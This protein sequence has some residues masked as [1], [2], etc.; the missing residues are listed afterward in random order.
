MRIVA[1]ENIPY[2]REAFGCLGQVV[3]LKGRSLSAKDVSD[4]EVLLV[5]SVT[6]VDE[7]LLDGCNVR[8]IGTATI[9]FDH[10]D[11]EYLTRRGIP[12]VTAAGSNANSVAEYVMAAL[13]TLGERKGL[14]WAGKTIGVVGVGNIGRLVARDAAAMGMRVLQN[15]PPRQRA[16][17][18]TGFVDLDTICREADVITCHVPLNK[19]GPDRTFHLFDR[20]RLA[21]LRPETVL[22]NSSRGAVVDNTALLER[23]IGGQLQACVLDVWEP[24]PAINPELLRKVDVGTP[25]IAGYSFD[26]KVAGT[27]MLFEAVRRTF[28]LQVT[29]DPQTC[30]PATET[31]TIEVDARG[32]GDQA[33]MRRVARRLYDIE[34]DDARLRRLIALPSEQQP[35]YFDQLRK[36]Y[37]VRREF[38]NTQIALQ[39][40]SATL[41]HTLKTWGFRLE[42]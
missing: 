29:W 34:A 40:A 21:R 19:E 25:H 35:T 13:L 3:T 18:S 20:E 16:E 17:G 27:W 4:A 33:V 1:D 14:T 9:G 12:F 28:D 26:G 37:P 5:R 7:R 38:H 30:M 24:E 8:F 23:L 10:V 11:T 6:R 41:A 39:G 2:V 31:P 42:T 22:I 15:D 36:D 32:Q